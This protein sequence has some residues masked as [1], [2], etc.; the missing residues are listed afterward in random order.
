MLVPLLITVV[1]SGR[2]S[3]IKHRSLLSVHDVKLLV[4]EDGVK[5]N[6]GNFEIGPAD[7]R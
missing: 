6:I 7:W 5:N 3:G 4:L 1:V 2:V